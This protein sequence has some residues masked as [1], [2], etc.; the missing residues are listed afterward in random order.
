VYCV[1][2][3]S[4]ARAESYETCIGAELGEELAAIKVE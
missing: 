2:E 4:T 3:D 1:E